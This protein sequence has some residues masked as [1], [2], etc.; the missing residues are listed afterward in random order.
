[1]T[2][3]QKEKR[4]EYM[5]EYHKQWRKKNPQKEGEYRKKVWEKK[6]AQMYPTIPE[7]LCRNTEQVEQDD[8]LINI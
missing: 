1:M 7:E 4:K 8:N 5:R 3:E 2:D 6:L